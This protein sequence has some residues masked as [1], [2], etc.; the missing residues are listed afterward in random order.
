MTKGKQHGHYWVGSDANTL[1]PATNFAFFFSMCYF[2]HLISG[3]RNNVT[4][5]Q[6]ESHALTS[7]CDDWPCPLCLRFYGLCL[8]LS[9]LLYSKI[10]LYRTSIRES[11]YYNLYI[12]KSC[13]DTT[14]KN[15]R[16]LFIVPNNWMV[17]NGEWESVWPMAATTQ[18]QTRQGRTIQER[19]G[20][21][22]WDPHNRV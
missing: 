15:S 22:D 17:W 2:E 8:Y 4:S 5:V 11:P 9:K 10:M 12:C 14:K 20:V 21:T 16:L 18:N 13:N 6:I 19:L 1:E 7:F 3:L